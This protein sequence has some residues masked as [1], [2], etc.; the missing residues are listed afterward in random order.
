M[1]EEHIHKKCRHK[2][3]RCVRDTK[4]RPPPKYQKWDWHVKIRGMSMMKLET[5][6]NEDDNII[7][8]GDEVIR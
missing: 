8:M 1:R 7:D 3:Q 2:Y 5:Q 4:K 6:D